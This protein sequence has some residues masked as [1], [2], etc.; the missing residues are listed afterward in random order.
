MRTLV[1]SY[2]NPNGD[3]LC[4]S[5]YSIDYIVFNLEKI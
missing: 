1:L 4:T 5:E 3:L 2:I